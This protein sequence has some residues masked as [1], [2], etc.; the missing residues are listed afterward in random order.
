MAGSWSSSML[1][2]KYTL[3]HVATEQ[4]NFDSRS[5]F[6]EFR[7]FLKFLSWFIA[8]TWSLWDIGLRQCPFFY[9][10][11]WLRVYSTGTIHDLVF[12][13]KGNVQYRTT[14]HSFYGTKCATEF[15]PE[16]GV[17]VPQGATLCRTGRELASIRLPNA[18]TLG[19]AWKASF[20]SVRSARSLENERTVYQWHFILKLASVKPLFKDGL[21]IWKM[22][23][24]TFCQETYVG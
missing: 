19:T 3:L 14:R 21:L 18:K 13:S 7:I 16:L 10:F 4:N 23:M 12:R 15:P 1:M 2:E 17:P 8:Y 24:T 20:G 11:Y 6:C 9:F 22:R 5:C